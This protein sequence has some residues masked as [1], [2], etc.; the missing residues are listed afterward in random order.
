M[1]HFFVLKQF[2]LTSVSINYDY[3]ENEVYALI[4]NSELI[5]SVIFKILNRWNKTNRAK[6]KIFSSTLNFWTIEWSRRKSRNI[7]KRTQWKQEKKSQSL[8]KKNRKRSWNWMSSRKNIDEINVVAKAREVC[9]FEEKW[10]FVK[11]R[12]KES[13]L[14]RNIMIW[15][16]ENCE[17]WIW[18]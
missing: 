4:S 11:S 8:E 17:W 3:W 12:F 1:N 6:T 16:T 15:K 7:E 2:F 10:N 13:E 14:W 5:K 18:L 9:E